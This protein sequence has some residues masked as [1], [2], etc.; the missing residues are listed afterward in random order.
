[1]VKN[2]SIFSPNRL[3][4][5]TVLRPSVDPIKPLSLTSNILESLSN[6]PLIHFHTM[7]RKKALFSVLLDGGHKLNPS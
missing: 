6:V 1:M 2:V 3:F 7:Q 4:F 5:F